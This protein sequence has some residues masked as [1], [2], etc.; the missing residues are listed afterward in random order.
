MIYP[1]VYPGTQFA[2]QMPENEANYCIEH[3][4]VLFGNVS[5]LFGCE[6]FFQIRESGN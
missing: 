5:T 1:Y 3:D 4:L 6:F 2:Y